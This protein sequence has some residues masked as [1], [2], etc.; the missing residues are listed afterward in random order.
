[1]GILDYLENN[2]QS[3]LGSDSNMPMT[4]QPSPQAPPPPP[5]AAMPQGG[6]FAPGS[7]I[8]TSMLAPGN[9]TG[10]PPMPPP[11]PQQ[12]VHMAQAGLPTNS[13]GVDP[14][15]PFPNGAAALPGG[16]SPS[17]PLPQP[18][19]QPPATPPAPGYGVASAAAP[20]SP[21]DIRP[22]PNQFLPPNSAPTTMPPPSAMNGGP[23]PSTTGSLAT[24][25]GLT[26]TGIKTT[27]AGLG[28]GLAAAGN[29]RPGTPAGQA[30]AVGAGNAL[31]GRDAEENQTF[32]QSSTAFRD[33]M[34]AKQ[35]KDNEGYNQARAQYFA[36]RAQSMANGNGP[37]GAT[38]HNSP[39]Q[40]ALSIESQITQRQKSLQSILQRQWQ[41]NNASP[42]KQQDDLTNMQKQLNDFRTRMY[43]QNGLDPTK[44]EEYVNRG[45]DKTNPFDTKGMTQQRFDTEVPLGAWYKNTDGR[46]MQRTVPP[47]GTGTPQSAN[48]PQDVYAADQM[49]LQPPASQAIQ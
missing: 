46:V 42:E 32:A 26:P 25:L 18:R 41:M 35:Q 10:A 19:P 12:N 16:P 13:Q 29:M 44:S 15:A 43:K 1:M 14:N 28:S 2:W 22:D 39:Q 5:A 7:T 27:M 47:A 3:L 8:D 34:L 30:F 49:A 11:T 31:K 20:G 36:A 45:I 6:Q 24:A 21:M 17:V 23:T 40:M 4:A 37:N 38:G 33:M 9:P 48:S